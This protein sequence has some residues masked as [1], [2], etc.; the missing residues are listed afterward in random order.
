MS[1]SAYT[2][3]NKRSTPNQSLR[4]YDLIVDGTFTPPPAPVFDNLLVNNV[5]TV[6]GSLAG[7]AFQNFKNEIIEYNIQKNKVVYVSPDGSDGILGR[8]SPNLPYKTIQFALDKI[9]LLGDSTANNMYQICLAPGRYVENLTLYPFISITSL[10]STRVTSYIDGTLDISNLDVPLGSIF[11]LNGV[12]IV[13][14]ITTDFSAFVNQVVFIILNCQLQ[15]DVTCMGSSVT[16]SVF[17]IKDSLLNMSNLSF[18]SGLFFVDSNYT[19]FN[20][21]GDINIDNSVGNTTLIQLSNNELGNRNINIAATVPGQSVNVA[22]DS[23]LNPPG[24]FNVTDSAD[25]TLTISDNLPLNNNVSSLTLATIDRYGDCFG[26]GYEPVNPSVWNTQFGQIPNNVSS[27]LDLL[28]NDSPLYLPQET[29]ILYVSTFGDDSNEGSPFLQLRTI[30]KAIDL[31]TGFGDCTFLDPYEIRLAPGQQYNDAFV[32][33]PYT[34]IIGDDTQSTTINT[35][36]DVSLIDQ[37][38][39]FLTFKNVTLSQTQNFN[40]TPFVNSQVILNFDDVVFG[41]QTEWH[42]N[43]VANTYVNISGC[44]FFFEKYFL[45]GG[46]YHINN[47]FGSPG[48]TLFRISNESNSD[49]VVIMNSVSF[50]NASIEIS[51][52]DPLFQVDVNFNNVLNVGSLTVADDPNIN[53]TYD[54][55]TMPNNLNSLTNTILIKASDAFSVGYTPSSTWTT[56]PD[57]V[58]EALDVLNDSKFRLTSTVPATFGFTSVG[59]SNITGSALTG[60]TINPAGNVSLGSNLSTGS[61]SFGTS[62]NNTSGT[63]TRLTTGKNI[64]IQWINGSGAADSNIFFGKVT[65]ANPTPATL[66]GTALCAGSAIFSGNQ[67]FHLWGTNN[68]L[69]TVPAANVTYFCNLR[70]VFADDQPTASYGSII[71][72]FNIATTGGI[73]YTI[74]NIATVYSF[75]TFAVPVTITPIIFT[76]FLRIQVTNPNAGIARYECT[77]QFTRIL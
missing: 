41:N 30:Q 8:G 20:I 59:S 49:A 25:I 36:I 19:S 17:V 71:Y 29:R 46:G 28:V 16:S 22:F 18:D 24:Q 40:M 66:G 35:T 77:L 38:Q 1:V 39:G 26:D 31:I 21:I 61:N 14:P 2:Q 56:V 4:C 9:N 68:D 13:Q 34:S 57:N 15:D 70:I 64:S 65:A 76:N 73:T 62:A 60:F 74:P 27:A 52:D 44:T 37:P 58:G 48:C 55:L 69:Y 11:Q 10:G 45:Y 75:Q 3:I 6:G 5:L 23:I 50:N 47:C 42:G 54:L 32:P 51:I 63:Y 43:T 33:I 7:I 12:S 72:N 67:T 53:F